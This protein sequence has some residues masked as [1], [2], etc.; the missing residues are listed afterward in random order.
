MQ[1]S[2]STASHRAKSLGLLRDEHSDET[3]LRPTRKALEDT[4][5]VHTCEPL[6]AAPLGRN[7]IHHHE[8]GPAARPGARLRALRQAQ[9]A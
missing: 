8:R 2:K 3:K 5:Q 1:T 4:E 7:A 9:E 6:R